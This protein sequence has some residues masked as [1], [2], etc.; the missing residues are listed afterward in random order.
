MR[1]PRG[2]L[3]LHRKE[4]LPPGVAPAALLVLESACCCLDPYF[5]RPYSFKACLPHTK[6]VEL[7]LLTS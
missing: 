1:G 6:L 5:A 2:L 7:C 4:N 3:L